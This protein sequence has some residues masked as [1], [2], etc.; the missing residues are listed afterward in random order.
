MPRMARPHSY[1]INGLPFQIRQD[2]ISLRMTLLRLLRRFDVPELNWTRY[3]IQQ[4]E[5]APH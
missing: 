1:N 5:V 2:F 3:N 4:L